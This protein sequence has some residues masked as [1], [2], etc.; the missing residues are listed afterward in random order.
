MRGSCRDDPAEP[1]DAADQQHALAEYL[2]A[3]T[4]G[5]AIDR[6]LAESRG[7]GGGA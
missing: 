2:A 4:L 3:P 6:W 7:R 1:R 5:S